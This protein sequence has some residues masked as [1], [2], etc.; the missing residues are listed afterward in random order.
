M[1]SLVIICEGQTEVLFIKNMIVPYLKRYN[2]FVEK[3]DI[4]SLGGGINLRKL[5]EKVN[6]PLNQ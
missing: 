3:N 5:K 6:F 2:I 1:T 4:I